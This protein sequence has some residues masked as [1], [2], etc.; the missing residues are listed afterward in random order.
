MLIF[1]ALGVFLGSP[2]VETLHFTA[3]GTG[4]VPGQGAK[5]LHAM[6]HSQKVN[7]NNV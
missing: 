1:K 7:D 4:L 6:Q 2:V 5:I 3:G